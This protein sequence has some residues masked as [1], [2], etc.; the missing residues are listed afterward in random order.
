MAIKTCENQS[1]TIGPGCNFRAG[2][3]NITSLAVSEYVANH[4]FGLAERPSF[5]LKHPFLYTYSQKTNHSFDA[6][7]LLQLN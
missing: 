4:Q 3:G 1:F 2:G 7:Q 6:T 5:K